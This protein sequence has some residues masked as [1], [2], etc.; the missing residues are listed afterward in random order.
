MANF[1]HK[2]NRKAQSLG[3]SHNVSNSS[4]RRRLQPAQRGQRRARTG[5]TSWADIY[6]TALHPH[7]CLSAPYRPV[8]PNHKFQKRSAVGKHVFLTFVNFCSKFQRPPTLQ[9]QRRS[10]HRVSESCLFDVA[11]NL[12]FRAR[13]SSRAFT[14]LS[15]SARLRHSRLFSSAQPPA[16]DPSHPSLFYHLFSGDNLTHHTPIHSNTRSHLPFHAGPI[17]ALSFLDKRPKSLRSEA[18][19]GWLPALTPDGKEA[20]LEDFVQNGVYL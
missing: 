10:L 1:Q 18:I 3:T 20:T 16:K 12:L 9:A 14:C 19:L 7:R 6:Q 13:Y 5:N 4:R 2:H 17:Y 11:M 15:S 8:V